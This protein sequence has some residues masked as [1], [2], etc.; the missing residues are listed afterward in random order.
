MAREPLTN[1]IE[2]LLRSHPE[3]QEI[4]I[5]MWFPAKRTAP[6]PYLVISLDCLLNTLHLQSGIIMA[7]DIP[8]IMQHFSNLAEHADHS[9]ADALRQWRE[10][11]DALQE[12]E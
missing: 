12:P 3:M 2:E 6:K 9:D 5:Q 4:E 10:I 1:A 11:A 7:D 8:K